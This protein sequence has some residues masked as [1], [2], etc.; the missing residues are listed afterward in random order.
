M[1]EKFQLEETI[2]FA[3]FDLVT[4]CYTIMVVTE[5]GICATNQL[6]NEFDQWTWYEVKSVSLNCERKQRIKMKKL[7]GQKRKFRLLSNAEVDRFFDAVQFYNSTKKPLFSFK[8]KLILDH[9]KQKKWN[10]CLPELRPRIKSNNNEDVWDKI[11]ILNSSGNLIDLE[12]LKLRYKN[13]DKNGEE[14]FPPE[15]HGSNIVTGAE[16]STRSL[17]SRKLCINELNEL[18]ENQIVKP[19]DIRN[20]VKNVNNVTSKDNLKESPIN[21]IKNESIESIEIIGS[22]ESI[23][24][25][26]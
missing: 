21:E 14:V 7:N 3:I 18:F 5:M 4:N 22:I 25:T 23:E 26:E 17:R 2:S 19:S 11:R 6:N 16:L 20:S 13:A 15:V 24:S 8:R 1:S 9:K 12:E 10:A